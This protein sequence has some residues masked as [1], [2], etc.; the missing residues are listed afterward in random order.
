MKQEIE[1]QKFWMISSSKRKAS[2]LIIILANK[3]F[4]RDFCTQNNVKTS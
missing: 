2:F 4:N 1:I 3:I